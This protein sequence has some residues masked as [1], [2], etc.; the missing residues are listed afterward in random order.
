M[1]GIVTYKSK[2]KTWL[3]CIATFVVI[4]I[5]AFILFN[6]RL[7]DPFLDI[8]VFSGLFWIITY[9]DIKRYNKSKK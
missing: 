8:I 3:I 7:R 9:Y 2:L 6:K 5:I 4:D 1:K